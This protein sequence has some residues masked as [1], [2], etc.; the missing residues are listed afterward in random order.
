[1][2]DGLS[3]S[4]HEVRGFPLA[5]EDSWESADVGPGF[6]ETMGIP[7]LRGRSIDAADFEQRRAVSVVNEAWV[8]QFLPTIDPIGSPVG[9]VGIVGDVKLARV[10]HET[11]PMM[12]SLL[13]PEPDRIN[14][15][16]VRT[17]GD[18]EAVL[19]A[20]REAVRAINPQLFVGTRTM[21]EEI[22][23]NLARERLVAGLS[24]F[25]GLLGLLLVSIGIF[26]V[27]SYTVA[28]RTR[29][30]GIRMA[31]GAARRSVIG[32][33]LRETMVVFG[34]GLVA[35][36]A[37]AVVAVRLAASFI[38]DLLFGLTATD[39]LTVVVAALV[40]TGVSVAA[41]ALPAR[42]A[43]SIDPLLAIRQD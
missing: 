3:R 18:P 14:A 20:I 7:I 29:E 24:G 17:L 2:R 12:Y 38:A 27:A 35:G 1:M 6:F 16:E 9:I 39:A 8:R 25:L 28:Q 31:L 4:R 5:S 21:R 15:L 41:C 32:A 23:R 33:A 40:L 43:A 37:A 10:R 26:G 22:D 19:P 30:L 36:V 42:R 11:G 34:A 13:Q